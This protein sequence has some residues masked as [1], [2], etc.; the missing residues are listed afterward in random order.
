MDKVTPNDNALENVPEESQTGM[1]RRRLLL[2]IVAALAAVLVIAGG[3]YGYLYAATPEPIRNPAFE[4]YH[5]RTQIVVNGQ[6]V[7]FSADEFQVKN[8]AA[9]CSAEPGS[10]PIDFHDNVDQMTHI[11]WDGI[12]GGQFLKYYG[13][14]FTGGRDDI[15]GYRYDQG[16]TNPQPVERFGDLLPD[17]PDDAQF[18][19]YIGDQDGYEQKAWDDFLSQDLEDFF[20]QQ[21]NLK[22]NEQADDFSLLDVFFK[23]VAAHGPADELPAED[24][25]DLTKEDLIRINN[26]IG[27]VVIFVQEDEPTDAEV[28]ARFD[29]LVPLQATSSC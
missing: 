25:E 20:G 18:Y 1:K 8:D 15:L 4:H 22:Q 21:S 12:T 24:A 10:H 11:H 7:N 5:F 14:N 6:P 3:L 17:V 29:N 2:I 26:L 19:V 16:L 23:K 13:W 9:G 28:Q 27:N